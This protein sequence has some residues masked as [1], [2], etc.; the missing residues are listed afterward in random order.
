MRDE[1]TVKDQIYTSIQQKELELHLSSS[2]VLKASYPKEVTQKNLPHVNL[3]QL[4]M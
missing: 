3:S 1:D 4:Q 2:K